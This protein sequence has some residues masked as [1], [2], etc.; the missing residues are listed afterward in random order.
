MHEGV[1]HGRSFIAP[2]FSFQHLQLSKADVKCWQI[3]FVES[4]T[5]FRLDIRK[6]FSGPALA[7]AA[8]GGGGVI[9]GGIHEEGGCHTEGCGLVGMVGAGWG[10]SR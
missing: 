10:W 4:F 9:P 3:G 8:Q 2:R 1:N 6:D 5:T 7:Q